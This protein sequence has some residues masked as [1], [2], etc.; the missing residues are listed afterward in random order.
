MTPEEAQRAIHDADDLRSNIPA[1]CWRALEF[2]AG[3]REEWAREARVMGDTEW[4]NL[5]WCR[6]RAE[7]ELTDWTWSIPRGATVEY[8]VVRRYVTE[9][10]EA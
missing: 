8:R 6:S 10:E 4:F 2:V 5:R 1:Y 7:A 9:P 3:T